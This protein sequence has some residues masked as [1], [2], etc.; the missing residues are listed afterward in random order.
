MA[1]FVILFV[2]FYF[3][4]LAYSAHETLAVT[5]NT[6]LW[7]A[8]HSLPLSNENFQMYQFVRKCM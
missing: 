8:N 1:F 6:C 5:L 2:E 7:L 4:C 3:Y